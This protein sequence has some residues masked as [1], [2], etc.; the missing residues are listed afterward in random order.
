M[1]VGRVKLVFVQEPI[2]RP[3]RELGLAGRARDV[4]VAGDEKIMQV[5]L[6]EG[7]QAALAQ[8]EEAGFYI[9]FSKQHTEEQA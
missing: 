8:R 9:Q 4:T 6:F 1:E 3:A 7:R 2:K 5:F